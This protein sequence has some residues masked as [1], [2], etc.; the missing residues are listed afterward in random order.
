[1]RKFLF[2]F[3]F[4]MLLA[5]S[6]MGRDWSWSEK[7]QNEWLPASYHL[8]HWSEL[9]APQ[10]YR[11]PNSVGDYSVMT[12]VEGDHAWNSKMEPMAFKVKSYVPA[13]RHPASAGGENLEQHYYWPYPYS[14]K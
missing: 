2:T 12:Y 5:N 7:T 10:S 8:K 6:A 13:Y 3:T 1:M 4:A 11:V 9:P 14:W